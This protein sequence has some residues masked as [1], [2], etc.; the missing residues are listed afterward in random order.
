MHNSVLIK[1]SLIVFIQ[2]LYNAASTCII[3]LFQEDTI[4][5]EECQ[6]TLSSLND[7]NINGLEIN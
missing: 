1:S 6:V 7:I 4:L 3:Q 5:R 2:M